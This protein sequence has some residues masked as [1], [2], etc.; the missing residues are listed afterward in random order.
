VITEGPEGPKAGQT[1]DR[2]QPR[3][4]WHRGLTQTAF[5]CLYAA[6]LRV[7]RCCARGR[8]GGL[9]GIGVVPSLK[10]AAC[11]PAC[12]QQTQGQTGQLMPPLLL[13]CY[14]P[15]KNALTMAQTQCFTS[16]N[17]ECMLIEHTSAA[18]RGFVGSDGPRARVACSAPWHVA[19]VNAA[20]LAPKHTAA[21]RIEALGASRAA[22]W[23]RRGQNQA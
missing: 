14:C 11:C 18:G 12:G 15:L 23:W 7:Y 19:L 17:H 10:G 1:F 22:L 5:F 9:L 2:A 16:W 20:Y 13:L 8:L 21:T 6:F 3:C 4:Q